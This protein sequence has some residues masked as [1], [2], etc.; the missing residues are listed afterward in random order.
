MWLTIGGRDGLY[1]TTKRSKT[2][3]RRTEYPGTGREQ[4]EQNTEPGT[5]RSR[6]GQRVAALLL[7]EGGSIDG[8]NDRSDTIQQNTIRNDLI[9]QIALLYLL[10][11]LHLA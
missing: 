2:S 9:P 6:E 1:N 7:E 8:M 3:V 5:A 11:S 10:S 4:Q